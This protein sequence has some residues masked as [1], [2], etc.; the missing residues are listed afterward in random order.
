MYALNTKV[1]GHLINYDDFIIENRV[2]PELWEIAK[3]RVDWE[4]DYIM[5]ERWDVASKDDE[6]K[7]E[8]Q[9][10][11]ELCPDVYSFPLVT[12]KFCDDLVDEM[13]HFGEWSGGKNEDS[14]LAGGYENVPTVDIHMRQ[15]SFQEEWLH[16]LKTYVAPLA[17][18]AY[19]G[20]HPDSKA[21]M[22]FVVR[23]HPKEQD[24]LRPHFDSSTFSTNIA[25]R[26]IG[27]D[28]EGGG[29]RFVRYN[30]SIT[31]QK[32]GWILMHP[33]RLTHWHE[34]LRVTKGVRYIAVSFVDP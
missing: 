17:S 33:G 31:S 12:T 8:S 26:R 5:P 6:G 27:I 28:F 3:N 14:R 34:G 29:T 22:N 20:Y 23:H 25:L 4:E 11:Y 9:S 7:I 32:Q 21:I 18:Y 30:C 16:L 19:T 10:K 1:F 15:I 2:H 24:H 13:E